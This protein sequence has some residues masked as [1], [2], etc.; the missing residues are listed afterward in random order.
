VRD[1]PR[2]RSDLEVDDGERVPHL[3]RIVQPERQREVVQRDERLEPALAQRAEDVAVVLDRRL[4]GERVERRE[5]RRRD[6][7]R[8]VDAG[9]RHRKDPAPLD[10]HPE[11]VPVQLPAHE[12]RILLEE[13]PEAR[14]VLREGPAHAP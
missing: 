9:R 14:P 5:R 1:P 6:P 12:L 11:R 4:I 7:A 8:R 2:H 10:A 3:D 13:P